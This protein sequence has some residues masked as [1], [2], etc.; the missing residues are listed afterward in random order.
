MFVK[1]NPDSQKQISDETL[2]MST[3]QFSLET[4]FHPQ[5]GSLKYPHMLRLQ[6]INANYNLLTKFLM[7]K[8]RHFYFFNFLTWYEVQTYT[9]GTLCTLD[10]SHVTKMMASHIVCFCQGLSLVQIS[11]SYHIW[12]LRF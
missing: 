10:I 9:E 1:E 2:T 4:F 11:T 12:K 7:E 5:V 3:K 6:F 8:M